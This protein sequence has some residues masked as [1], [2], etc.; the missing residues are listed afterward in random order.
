MGKLFITVIFVRFPS[1]DL[2]PALYYYNFF[3]P[4]YKS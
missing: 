4:A 3:K 2:G 1:N